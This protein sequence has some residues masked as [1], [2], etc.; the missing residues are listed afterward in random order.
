MA[1]L[2]LFHEVAAR[3]QVPPVT[4]HPTHEWHSPDPRMCQLAGGGS[5][6]ASENPRYYTHIPD[7]HT[8]YSM[9]LCIIC[10]YLHATCA[11]AASV[12]H[13]VMQFHGFSG[14]SPYLGGLRVAKF[15]YSV[16]PQCV[17]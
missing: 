12:M 16:D 15:A 1:I 5:K 4:Y 6:K 9:L 3:V 14:L 8:P 11:F 17:N 2:V 10:V 13:L 7:P